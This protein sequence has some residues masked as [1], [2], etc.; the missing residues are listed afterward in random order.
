MAL[1]DNIIP[2]LN[3]SSVRKFPPISLAF[4]RAA[5]KGMGHFP[6]VA[7]KDYHKNTSSYFRK[8]SQ[9]TNG[10]F[11]PVSENCNI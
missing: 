5:L 7:E 4:V 1:M 3:M 8:L 11:L 10:H 2:V 9:L 6:P